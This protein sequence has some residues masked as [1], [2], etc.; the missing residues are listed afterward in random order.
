MYNLLVVDDEEI[1]VRGIVEGIDWTDLPFDQIFSASDV[2]EA[3]RAF[4][5]HDIHVL[6][7]DIDMP[8]YSGIELLKWV[9]EHSPHTE[10]IFLSGHANFNYAQQALQLDSFD[11][12]LK[13]IDHQHIKATI[14]KAIQKIKE[15]E[16]HHEFH[17]TYEYYYQQWNKQLPI[18]TERFW[19]DVLNQRI[20]LGSSQLSQSFS[21]Y[22]IPL[23]PEDEVRLILISV[24]SWNETL[25]SRDEEIMTYAIK[26]AGEEIILANLNGQL[27]QEAGG[28]VYAIV[29]GSQ[30]DVKGMLDANCQTFIRMCKTY[31][32]CE[33][34]CYIS[35]PVRVAELNSAMQHL[36][37]LERTCLSV[38]GTVIWQSEEKELHTPMS[39]DLQLHHMSLLLE[40]GKQE[41][42]MQRLD[43][44]LLGM[45]RNYLDP[46]VLESYYHGLV[47]MVQETLLK[48]SIPIKEVYP[49]EAWRISGSVCKS[50]QK[51]RE[52]AIPFMQ[53]SVMYIQ[54]HHHVISPIVQ[55]VMTYIE[56]HIAVELSREEIA[57]HVY[58]NPA[59]LSRLFKKE[60]GQSL[61]EFILELRMRKVKSLLESTNDK[62]SDIAKSV[63][64]CNFS[65]FTKTF[66][67]MTGMTPNEYRRHY[68]QV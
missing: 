56:D 26:N 39:Y 54:Q 53:R 9:K 34:S 25:S 59:Y 32:H 24:E 63:G 43:T 23:Q 5:D 13:P 44:C 20:P 18:L 14:Q 51:F 15:Q 35:D 7:S 19:Q 31:L 2:E 36:T 40:T 57:A 17:K 11:Y 52:W 55:K 30:Q 50:L 1:A 67:K 16:N 22:Q 61:T 12:L 47:Y 37:A 42:L 46:I 33:L 66:K 60:T 6:L 65:H 10:T 68:Q 64:F 62:I 41:E 4:D 3:I 48:K 8:D 58:L 29:Y 49:D 45:E 38:G 21:L 27:V 28:V